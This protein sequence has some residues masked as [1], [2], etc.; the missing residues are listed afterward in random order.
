MTLSNL[1]EFVIR[2]N[3]TH[4]LPLQYKVRN[5][6]ISGNVDAPEGSLDALLQ[7]IVC[8]DQIGWRRQARRLLILSTDA[9]FHHAGDGRVG[10]VVPSRRGWQSG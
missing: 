4:L 3:L 8:W 5:T 2:F 6:P 10:S 1:N 7:A 9:R